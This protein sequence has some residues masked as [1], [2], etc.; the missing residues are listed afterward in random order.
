MWGRLC[1]WVCCRSQ[2]FLS[3]TFRVVGSRARTEVVKLGGKC[4]HSLLACRLLVLIFLCWIQRWSLGSPLV[5]HLPDCD[6]AHNVFIYWGWD[7]GPQQLLSNVPGA[8]T[9]FWACRRQEVHAL[10]RQLEGA[11]PL[12]PPGTGCQQL[13]SWA[14]LL[15]AASQGNQWFS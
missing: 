12:C 2:F 1:Q 13:S 14:R 3:T 9:V 15:P 5:P 11:L 10:S 8:T 7:R 6:T 4:L